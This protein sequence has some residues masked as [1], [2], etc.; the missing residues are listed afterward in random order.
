MFYRPHLVQKEGYVQYV[1]VENFGRIQTIARA[2]TCFWRCK[3]PPFR[4][5]GKP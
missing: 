2:L 4:P 1:G 3:Y 5:L